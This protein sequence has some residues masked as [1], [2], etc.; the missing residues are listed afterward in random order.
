MS[1]PGRTFAISSP[2]LTPEAG[3]I[4]LDIQL[5][6]QDAP[7]QAGRQ[8]AST[9]AHKRGETVAFEHAAKE[10]RDLLGKW[11]YQA[12]SSAWTTRPPSSIQIDYA[13]GRNTTLDGGAGRSTWH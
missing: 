7:F 4:A 1:Q 2:L 12:F 11:A 6:W 10:Q 8:Q 13:A 9:I 5:R 3:F